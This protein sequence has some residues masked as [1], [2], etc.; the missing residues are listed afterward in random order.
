[1]L[2]LSHTKM[3][4]SESVEPQRIRSV[5]GNING[6]SSQRRTGS[7]SATSRLFINAV[8][9]ASK[10]SRGTEENS[11]DKAHHGKRPYSPNI[12]SFKEDQK[13]K[14][15]RVDGDSGID[16][17]RSHEIDQT[18]NRS[19]HIK[20]EHYSSDHEMYDPLSQDGERG[21][22]VNERRSQV[23]LRPQQQS[24]SVLDRLGK[25]GGL[26]NAYINPAFFPN[27]NGGSDLSQSN[28]SITLTP[29]VSRCRH[30]PNCDLGSACKFH[31]PTE[32][33]PMVPNCPN[34]PRTCL[35]IHPASQDF[36]NRGLYR[37]G[38]YGNGSMGQGTLGIGPN[39][40][41]IDPIGQNPM[42]H[43]GIGQHGM[44]QGMFNPGSFHFP[45][46]L[47][48]T[49]LYSATSLRQNTLE[50]ISGHEQN[51]QGLRDKE[52]KPF[53]SGA[54]STSV[55]ATIN[56]NASITATSSSVSA[57]SVQEKDAT[58]ASNSQA[59]PAV[60]C[61]YGE[62]CAN[63][64]CV[65]AHASPSTVGTGITASSLLEMPCKYGIEC[66]QTKC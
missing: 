39:A 46:S 45:Q 20:N 2:I 1:F 35:Y 57:E 10:S 7:G 31:H 24:R 55:T 49:D 5:A 12:D 64:N 44:G 6:R 33:C 17:S 50:N 27:S 40:F 3:Y 62:R 51:F 66:G 18:H 37:F 9:D 65:Y 16:K 8:K 36:D 58:L 47:A 23:N 41:V 59:T 54:G 48:G 32:I 63:P 21:R 29:K 52:Q 14:A 11:S 30:W 61:K 56:T 15:R 34:S 13:T 26:M 60:L 4:S 28:D 38:S 53:R 43:F 25:K 42:G 22:F 19:L